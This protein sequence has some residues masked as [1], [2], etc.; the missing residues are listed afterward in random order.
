MISIAAVVAAAALAAAAPPAQ[1]PKDMVCGAVSA[2]DIQD[3]F[4][5]ILSYS[6]Y[7]NTLDDQKPWG[8]PRREKTTGIFKSDDASFRTIGSP[9]AAFSAN[10]AQNRADSTG[11]MAK[12]SHVFIHIPSMAQFNQSRSEVA[13][14]LAH[15]ISHLMTHDPERLEKLSMDSFEKWCSD[16]PDPCSDGDAK[17]IVAKWDKATR[18]E[19]VKEQ[20]KM[21]EEAD[22]NARQWLT[23]LIDPRTG[24][25]FAT[26]AGEQALKSA[27]LWLKAKGEKLD[28]PEHGTLADRIEVL[29]K[30]RE[31]MDQ[32]RAAADAER[33]EALQKKAGAAIKKAGSGF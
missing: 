15:E 27:E 31:Q 4:D 12:A 10:T 33:T 25:P 13:Y 11:A 28:D 32:G 2:E 26:D 30:D 14:I 16:N 18:A 19:R 5:I 23:T 17:K 9:A 8:K 6:G 20:R 1:A 3:V 29:R 24:L 7:D 21:E 22:R